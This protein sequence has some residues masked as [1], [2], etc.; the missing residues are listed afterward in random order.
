MTL[1][2]RNLEKL[3]ESVKGVFRPTSVYHLAAEA[4]AAIEVRALFVR[5]V[6]RYHHYCLG[7]ACSWL[8]TPRHQ[9]Y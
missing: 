6:S 7:I 2:D 1:V 5:E 8:R 4:L 9:A 3:K